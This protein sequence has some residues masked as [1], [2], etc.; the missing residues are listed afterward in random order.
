MFIDVIMMK[1]EFR[2]TRNGFAH[3]AVAVLKGLCERIAAHRFGAPSVR[4]LLTDN[5]KH[6]R[7]EGCADMAQKEGGA[8]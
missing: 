8:K 3:D 5:N 7:H 4:S 1:A 6:E 2:K